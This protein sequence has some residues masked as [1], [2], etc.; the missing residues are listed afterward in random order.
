MKKFI[1]IPWLIGFILIIN[2]CALFSG[3]TVL[4][5]I[6]EINA[7]NLSVENEN[8]Q[9]KAGINLIVVKRGLWSMQSTYK[10]S[11]I[12]LY[13]KSLLD[14]HLVFSVDDSKKEFAQEKTI[15]NII[16]ITINS[17]Y[18]NYTAH[19]KAILLI[20]STSTLA[21]LNDTNFNKKEVPNMFFKFIGDYAPEEIPGIINAQWF[22]NR[23]ILITD[24]HGIIIE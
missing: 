19:E 2:G 3:G 20:A 14:N 12:N 11:M 16:N 23:K 8:F 6:N 18:Q 10:N 5:A 17:Q 13:Y 9:Q 15:D 4:Q 1:R 22:K 7:S 21:L 24:D